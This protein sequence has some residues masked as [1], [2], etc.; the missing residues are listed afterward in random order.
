M[1]FIESSFSGRNTFAVFRHCISS[2]PC[3]RSSGKAGVRVSLGQA[4]RAP[5]E[6]KFRFADACPTIFLS[7]LYG[8]PF[9]LLRGPEFHLN[10]SKRLENDV[11]TT[12]YCNPYAQQPVSW[13]VCCFCKENLRIFLVGNCADHCPSRKV[14]RPVG[15]CADRSESQSIAHEGW[16]RLRMSVHPLRTVGMSTPLCIGT[17]QKRPEN[18]RT[19]LSW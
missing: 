1:L 13:P 15:N 19:C 5:P 16:N 11:G 12:K 7:K 8:I 18:Q 17:V 9:E 10:H 4:R 3:G 14:C 2:D 6:I